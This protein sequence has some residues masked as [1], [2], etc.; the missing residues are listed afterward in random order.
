MTMAI[1]EFECQTCGKRFEVRMLMST[2]E[3]IKQSPPVCP[4]CGKTTTHQVVSE[5]ACNRPAS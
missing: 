3:Q 2:H 5:F 4:A 1:Y